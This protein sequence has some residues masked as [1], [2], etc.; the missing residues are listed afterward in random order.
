METYE[1]LREYADNLE[2]ELAKP[3]PLLSGEDLKAMGYRPGPL[4]SEILSTVEDEQ[5]EG[6]L[7]SPEDARRYVLE[8]WPAS[9]SES[10]K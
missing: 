7:S 4:F 3:P 9:R 5:L 8:H 10:K 6:R 1:W 2:P